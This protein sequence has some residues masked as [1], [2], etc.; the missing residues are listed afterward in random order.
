MSKL[1]ADAFF[2]EMEKISMSDRTAAKERRKGIAIG[3]ATAL[4]AFGTGYVGARYSPAL[5]QKILGS[6]KPLSDRAR[7]IIMGA[8]G[9][10]GAA[11]PLALGGYAHERSQK[12][13]SK[14]RASRAVQ[15]KNRKLDKRHKGHSAAVSTGSVLPTTAGSGV[16]PL[17][18]GSSGGGVGKHRRKGDG[19]DHYRSG[20]SKYEFRGKAPS[21]YTL[22]RTSGLREH[23]S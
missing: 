6:H 21:N 7:R 9:I 8:S 13:T 5:M 16:L 18:P 2:D 20:A 23:K 3:L 14:L 15:S 4:G 11:L 17:R 12:S 1:L 22:T 19:A 10:T